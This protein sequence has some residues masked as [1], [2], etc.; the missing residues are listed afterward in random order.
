[1]RDIN[2]LSTRAQIERSW[3]LNNSIFQE[4]TKEPQ[5][6]LEAAKRL[7]Q[8]LDAK[9]EKADLRAITENCTNLSDPDKQ[10]LLELLQEFE[11]LFD[12]TLGDW[13]CEPV[14]LQPAIKRR[15]KAISWPAI[16]NSQKAH[17]YC[18][19]RIPKIMWFGGITVGSRLWM[20][21]ANIYNTKEKQHCDAVRV[22]GDFRE[23]NK[24]IVRKPFPI[25]KISH[26]QNQHSSTRTRR[27][28]VCH[29]PWPKHGQLHH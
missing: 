16:S 22:V 28:Y 25:P 21:F 15:S 17:G 24:R 26:T 14:S 8:V 18:Q 6:T 1:M 2:K 9:N 3:S 12:G 4:N 27:L 13:D 11:E 10:K 23:L 20:G 5:S 7:I 19:K 29:W